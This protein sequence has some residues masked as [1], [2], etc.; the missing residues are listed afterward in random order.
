MILDVKIE[1]EDYVKGG[2]LSFKSPYDEKTPYT[3]VF[4]NETH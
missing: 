3:P 1:Y 4:L 2:R